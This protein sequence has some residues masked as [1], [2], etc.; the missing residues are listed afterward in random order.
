MFGVQK[1]IFAGKSNL[2]PEPF[3]PFLS[4]QSGYTSLHKRSFGIVDRRSGAASRR[5]PSLR[6][7]K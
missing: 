1:A 6:G 4:N 2:Q 3:C 5:R 7:G